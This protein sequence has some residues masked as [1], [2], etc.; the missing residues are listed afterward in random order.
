MLATSMVVVSG[1]SSSTSTTGTE[2]S[3]TETTTAAA[4]GGKYTAGTYT[5]EGA[6]FGGT[7]SVTI[8]TDADNI[9]DIKIEGAD[10]TPNIGGAAFEELVSADSFT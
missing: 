9:T 6:G 5:G 2:G 3:T 7:V 4:A 10:E 8:T 1:C